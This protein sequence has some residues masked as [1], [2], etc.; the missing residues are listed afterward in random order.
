MMSLARCTAGRT[1]TALGGTL[2]AAMLMLGVMVVYS[3]CGTA[4][5]A[6]STASTSPHP[7]IQMYSAT[8][9]VERGAP[10]SVSVSCRSDERMLG[11]GFESSNCFEYA[12]SI[13]A[14]Y[15]SGATTW[16][17]IGSAPAS[18][19]DLEADIYCVPAAMA[20]GLHVVQTSGIAMATATCPQD[21][22]LLGGG[23]QGS[24]PIG[25]S[26]SQG[27]GWLGATSDGSIQVYALCATRNVLRGRLVTTAFNP[28]STSHNYTPSVGDAGCPAGQI[29][30][31][32]GFAGGDLIMGSQTRGSSFA[33][34]SVAAGGDADVMVSAECVLLQ[35]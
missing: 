32:G 28:H 21:T 31:G 12:A 3:A 34:W 2:R 16:T 19:F 30:V 24:Q 11:G 4:P 9:R 33:G 7:P 18:Y 14:S 29:A 5:R 35:A 25:V 27:N 6:I 8:A 26:R 15:P 1:I 22:V 17:V 13:E 20:V 10:T 23:F